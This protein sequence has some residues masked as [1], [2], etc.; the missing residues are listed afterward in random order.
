MSTY[1]LIQDAY[2]G[3]YFTAGT[4]VS[5]QDVGGLLPV[6]WVP[7]PFVD[8]LDPAAVN[9]FYSAGPMR[10]GRQWSAPGPKPV[11]YW[12]ATPQPTN[13]SVMLWSLVGLGIGKAPLFTPMAHVPRSELRTEP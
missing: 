4:V 5:T 7:G 3:R 13:S 10:P 8:P 9:D 12:L 2:I 11:T 1:R 6:G